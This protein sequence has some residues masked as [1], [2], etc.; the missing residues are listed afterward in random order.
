[1]FMQKT[2]TFFLRVYQSE[3]VNIVEEHDFIW[4]LWRYRNRF[5]KSK[6]DIKE[7]V[8]NKI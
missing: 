8:L 6:N 1:M 2:Q 3:F 5:P 7:K 4:K